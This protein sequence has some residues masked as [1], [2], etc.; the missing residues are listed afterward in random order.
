MS[1]Q[2]K[3]NIQLHITYCF[4]NGSEDHVS[5]FTQK[6]YVNMLHPMK[7]IALLYML[8]SYLH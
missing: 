1:G 4:D 8:I 3:N 2:M 7:V 5:K 6:D